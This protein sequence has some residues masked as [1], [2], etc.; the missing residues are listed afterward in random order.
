MCAACSSG[1]PVIGE[2]PWL[3]A[4]PRQALAEW[5]S[6]LSLL[7]QHLASE[8]AAMRAESQA[9]ALP[10]STRRRLTQ[11]AAANDDQVAL[12]AT[13]NANIEEVP[14]RSVTT[15]ATA[16][17]APT[18]QTRP[19]EQPAKVAAA[20]ADG[21]NVRPA[22]EQAAATPEAQPPQQV[23]TASVPTG[24]YF[25]QVASLPSEAEAQKSYN[26]LSS[27]FG[28]VIGG[29]GV[30]IRKAEIAGK[31]TYYRVRIPAGS[32]EEANALCS[33]YKGAGGS[34]LVTK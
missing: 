32:K 6:R 13:G 26:S 20:A 7:T 11:V 21:G 34:C 27:K 30:D 16:D 18:P 17:K 24:G 12:A 9:A 2:I 31:G 10:A 4:D 14:V 25:I 1:Y 29:R 3:F 23:A 15:T 22:E 5:R 19:A 33:K 8:A 28:S